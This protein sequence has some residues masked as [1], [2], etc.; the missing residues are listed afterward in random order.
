MKLLHHDAPA[1]ALRPL[2]IIVFAVWFIRVAFKPLH[3]LA[4]IPDS[5]YHPV[6]LLALLPSSVE[7]LLRGAVVLQALQAAALLSFALVIA[8]IALRPM[9]VVSCV[10]MT[11]F[12]SLWRGFAGHI[13]H[14]SILILLAGYLLTLFAFADTRVAWKGERYVP[15]GPTRAGIQLTTILAVLLL[16][17]TVVGVYRTVRGTP[18]VYTTDSLTFWALRNSYE[19]AN[20]TGHFGR[21]VID[22]PWMGTMLSSGFPVVTLVELTAMLALFSRWYRYLFLA[23][24]VPFHVLSLF[25]LDVFFWENMALYVLFFELWYRPDA[26]ESAAA[27]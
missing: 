23:V 18:A 16:V 11:L 27:G 14:E 22:Y 21:Y 26:T 10:L 7:A 15:G 8:G 12:A 25:V 4:L 19:T 17:Y 24:M 3:Q 20:P 1:S 13:D 2:R 5:L 6:G 9:M